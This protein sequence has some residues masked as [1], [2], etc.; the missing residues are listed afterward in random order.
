VVMPAR[1]DARFDARA[2][3][4]KIFSP[5]SQVPG[6]AW[7]SWGFR[8]DILPQTAYLGYGCLLSTPPTTKAPGVQCSIG[9][10]DRATS[11]NYY[12]RTFVNEGK[13]GE[14]RVLPL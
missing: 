10:E 7:A 12:S 2:N 6:N 3:Y 13:E 1:N 8:E 5:E 4:Q 9:C 11:E 14:G